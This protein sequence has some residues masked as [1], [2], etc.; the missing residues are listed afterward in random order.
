[1]KRAVAAAAIGVALSGC[2]EVRHPISPQQARAEV[3]DAARDIRGILHGDVAEA[4]FWYEPCNDQGEP[5][6]R[7]AVQLLL[8]LPGVSHDKAVDP[9]QV[10]QTLTAH[11][12]STDSDFISHAPTLR[13]G[14]INIILTVPPP[15]TPDESNGAHVVAKVDGQCR[16]TFDHRTDHSI[17]HVDVREEIERS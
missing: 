9:Q 3:I 11:G 7:G 1:V 10:I 8:W 2:A 16:D 17:M 15:P 4:S 14:A 12:W 13:K 6:F 5:P